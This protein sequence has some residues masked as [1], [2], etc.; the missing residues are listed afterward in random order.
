VRRRWAIV[1]AALALAVLIPVYWIAWR[2]PAV[3]MFHDD[4]VYLVT[5][6]ALATGQGYRI[7][8]LPEEIPQT[9]YPILFP[10]VLSGVWRLAPEFPENVFVL[11]PLLSKTGRNL[12]TRVANGGF[13][14]PE[15]EFRDR[16]LPL[17]VSASCPRSL[18]S[19]L[20]LG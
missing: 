15:L 3:G 1:I 8:S 2:A 20:G 4:G 13:A 12:A 6:K 17:R 9:K 19:A 11:K 10:L 5:A 7:I 18:P 16:G 14:C